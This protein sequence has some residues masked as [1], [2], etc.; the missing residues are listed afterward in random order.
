[1]AWPEKLASGRYRGRYRDRQG[2]TLSLPHTY[3]QP[4]EAEREATLKEDAVRRRPAA[5]ARARRM[6]WG[7]WCDEWLADHRAVEPGTQSRDATRLNRHIRPYWDDVPLR[8]IDREAVAGWC[9]VVAAT[10]RYGKPKPGEKPVPLAPRTVLKI[11]TVFSASMTAAVVAG[12]IDASPC[13]H[14][15]L[16]QPAASDEH[17]LTRD[18]FARLSAEADEL[19]RMIAEFG[20]GTGLRWGEIAGMHRDRL[21][22]TRRRILVQEVFDKDNNEIKPYPKGRARRGVPITAELAA[23]LGAWMEAH[24]P[25]RCSARHRDGKACNGAL[26]FPSKVG[27]ALHYQNFRRRHWDPAVEKAGLG[28]V[29]PHDTRHTYASWL[30]QDGVTIE[31]LSKLLGHKAIST[32]QRYA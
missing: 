31:Q 12:K 11:A 9:R 24:P 30:I 27:T 20:V 14:L 25:V 17:F 23:K 15:R 26:L 16:D 6:T 21:D 8:D 18:E 3:T 5:K 28:G 13:T 4:A 7:E 19:T 10:P 2:K 1:M 29:T 22:T 32:T